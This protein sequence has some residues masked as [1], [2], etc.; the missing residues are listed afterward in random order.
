MSINF[1]VLRIFATSCLIAMTRWKS[2]CKMRANAFVK[3]SEILERW[4]TNDNTKAAGG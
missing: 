1:H 2:G 3:V 4:E